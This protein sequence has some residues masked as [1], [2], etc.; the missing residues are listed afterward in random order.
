MPL[1]SRVFIDQIKSTKRQ[2]HF[3]KGMF[4][5]LSPLRGCGHVHIKRLIRFMSEI[6][7]VILGYTYETNFN[8]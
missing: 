5:C 3:L 1:T 4:C 7:H 6:G 8:Y 2:H